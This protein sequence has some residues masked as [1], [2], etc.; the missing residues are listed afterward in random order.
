MWGIFFQS[1]PSCIV[2]GQL[3]SNIR[4]IIQSQFLPIH[5]AF[6]EKNPTAWSHIPCFAPV[7]FFNIAGGDGGDGDVQAQTS[8]I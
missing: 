6:E 1:F 3:Y 2:P 5:E 7:A 8:E 4:G